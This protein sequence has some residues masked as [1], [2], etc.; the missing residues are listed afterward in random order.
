MMDDKG[1]RG[2]MPT[3]ADRTS[4]LFSMMK[5][6]TA[7]RR[8]VMMSLPQLCISSAWGPQ[9][10]PGEGKRAFTGHAP[11]AA[12]DPPTSFFS[13]KLGVSEGR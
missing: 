11:N 3:Q 10:S 5:R 13:G 2:G 1:G 9:G 6:F 4:N 8:R 7:R 12:V